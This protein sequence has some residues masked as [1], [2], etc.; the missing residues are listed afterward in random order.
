M[1][2]CDVC[3][4]QAIGNEPQCRV[5]ETPL[6]PAPRPESAAAATPASK[7]RLGPGAITIIAVLC[8]A[9]G[10]GA[11][12]GADRFLLSPS[13]T[14]NE[15]PPAS[16]TPAPKP[17]ECLEVAGYELL[18][19]DVANLG[20]HVVDCSDASAV[21]LI[22]NPDE[23]ATYC[24]SAE[25]A[26]GTTISF[27]EIPAVGRCFFSYLTESGS[28]SGW[29]SRFVPCYATPDQRL[30]DYAADVAADLEVEVS[31]L[32]LAT[33]MVTSVS[34][35]EPT[36]ADGEDVWPLKYRDPAEWICYTEV[37]AQ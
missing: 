34:L 8:I 2:T 15:T 29:P 4:T 37:K 25:D 27:Y 14:A 23:C 10:F 16:D 36:C 13:A 1:R 21:T 35:E 7:G 30:V 3:D 33:L 19:S 11:G 6:P 9:L 18:H 20:S 5:C 26:A 31:T 24:Q 28:G 17:G 32:R 22:A 12:W